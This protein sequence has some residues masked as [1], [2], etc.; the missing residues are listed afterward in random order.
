MP[1]GA[2]HFQNPGALANLSL[3]WL[4]NKQSVQEGDESQELLQPFLAKY[5]L[6]CLTGRSISSSPG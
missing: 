6:K 1:T 2:E 4:G 3:P 5:R